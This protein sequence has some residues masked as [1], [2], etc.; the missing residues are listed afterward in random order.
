MTWKLW[1]CAPKVPGR[2]GATSENFDGISR[3][4]PV[5]HA[6]TTSIHAL[7]APSLFLLGNVSYGTPLKW[8]SRHFLCRWWSAGDEYRNMNYFCVLPVFLCIARNCS[9]RC[10][11][12]FKKFSCASSPH[13]S[14]AVTSGRGLHYIYSWGTSVPH[15]LQVRLRM[16][17]LPSCCPSNSSRTR[18]IS[19][20]ALMFFE[21]FSLYFSYV[22]TMTSTSFAHDCFAAECNILTDS[23]SPK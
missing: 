16:G 21:H 17:S 8:K 12:K 23:C 19:T 5:A 4:W 10:V 1:P 18:S 2:R 22:L 6:G 20:L 9:E 7:S 11:Q 3:C 15:G 13:L 14:G